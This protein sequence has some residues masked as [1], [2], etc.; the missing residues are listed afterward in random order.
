MASKRAQDIKILVVDDELDFRNA[1]AFSLKRRGYQVFMAS[2]GNEAYDLILSN[3]MDVIIADI[4]MPGGDGVGLLDRTRAERLNTPVILLV[5]GFSDLTAEE[6]N[7][8]GAEALFSKP[9]DQKALEETI[10]RLLAPLD[11]RL[12]QVPGSVNFELKVEL[13]FQGLCEAIEAKVIS[14]GRGGVFVTLHP[15]QF[16]NVNDMISFKLAFN[17]SSYSLTG[18]GIV[19]WVRTKDS[20]NS[21]SGCGIEFTYLGDVERKQLLEFIASKKPIAYIPKR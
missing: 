9:L 2:N 11:I 16:P 4:Q 6:A 18:G 8:K 14:L 7:S 1:L 20:A 3:P 17:D 15:G 12:T 19:R 13:Q 10:E 5:T 21:P